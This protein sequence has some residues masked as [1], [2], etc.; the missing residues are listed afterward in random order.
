MPEMSVIVV[1]WNGKHFLGDCL[2]ALRRQ[3]FRDFEVIFVDNGSL[4]GSCEYVRTAFP[5]VKV[6]ALPEN[7]GFAGGNISG[8]SAATGELILL[9]NNDT[10]AHSEWLQQIHEGSLRFPKAGSFASKMM[11]FDARERIENCGFDLGTSG[12]TLDLGRDELDGP[13]WTTPRPVFGAC[14]GAV[15]YRRSMLDDI[16]FLDPDFFMV[17]ED[18]DLSFRAQLRGYECIFVP[19]AIVFHRYRAT[20]GTRPA[21]QVFYSQRNIEFVYFKNMPAGLILRSAPQRLVYELGAAI[22]FIR[23]GQGGAFLRSKFS[24]IKHFSSLW[25]KRSQVQQGRTL[26]NSRLFG[27][28]RPAF[29]HKWRKLRASRV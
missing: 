3:T 22:F 21:P 19:T 15:A 25:R 20:L 7:T 9:L 13:N 28:M 14:G 12:A 8:Y 29:S 4:D 17:Y 6:V 16:G 18:V 10:E 2:S 23:H 26:G 5:E 27:L 11:Y 1:N 24:V